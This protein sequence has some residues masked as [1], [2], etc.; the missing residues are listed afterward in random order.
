MKFLQW[1][2]TGASMRFLETASKQMQDVN[3]VVL[4]G[5]AAVRAPAPPHP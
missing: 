2:H 3:S 5:C 4:Q 1:G